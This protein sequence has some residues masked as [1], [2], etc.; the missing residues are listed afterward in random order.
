MKKPFNPNDLTLGEVAAVEDLSGRSID[1]LADPA[2]P[3]GKL[4]AAITYVIKKREDSTYTFNQALGLSLAEIEKI[5][6]FG[7]MET[8]DQEQAKKDD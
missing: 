7:D 6:D 8:P 2:T 5:V 4:L 1:A 3:K